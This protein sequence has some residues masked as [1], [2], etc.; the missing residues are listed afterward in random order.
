MAPSHSSTITRIGSAPVI[1][2]GMLLPVIWAIL[3]FVLISIFFVWSRQQVLSLQYDIASIE[4]RIRHARQ[5]SAKLQVEAAM[6]RQ[7]RV[8]EDFAR[9]NLGMTMPDPRKI[10]VVR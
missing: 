2:R 6:L 1:H 3:G 4:S 8:I 7:P 9:N 10:I 5:E